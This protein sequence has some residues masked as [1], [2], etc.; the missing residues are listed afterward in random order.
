MRNKYGARKTLVDG[1]LFDSYAE[2]LMY[3][4]LKWMERTGQ[5]KNLE[6]QPKYT[7]IPSHSINGKIVRA[8]TYRPDFRFFDLNQNRERVIDC[9]GLRTRD[10]VLRSKMMSGLLNIE[11]EEAI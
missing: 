5:I 9:K 11:V 10:Y 6:L 4:Q 8:V 2:S 1:H 3:T 7:L